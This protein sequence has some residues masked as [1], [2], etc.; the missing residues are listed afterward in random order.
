MAAISSC[1]LGEAYV[2]TNV[3]TS[4]SNCNFCPKEIERKC[5]L[6]DRPVSTIECNWWDRPGVNRESVC[7]GCCGKFLPTP[8]PTITQE[9]QAGDTDFSF[10]TPAI[11][12]WNCSR[13]QDGCKE[14]YGWWI[15][16]VA[17]EMFKFMSYDGETI[18]VCTWCCSERTLSTAAL[19]SSLFTIGQ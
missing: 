15:L 19:G 8:P 16:T 3:T 14:R 10:P 9:C 18:Y 13:Y 2:V 12:P 4:D 7:E 5:K 11:H 6:Q 17:R 1:S